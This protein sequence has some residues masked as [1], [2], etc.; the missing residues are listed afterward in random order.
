MRNVGTI[1]AAAGKRL[2]GPLKGIDVPTLL[3][4]FATAP[5]LHDG[6]A[7]TLADAVRAHRGV[8]INDADLGNL[9]AY[10]QQIGG[11]ESAAPVNA[12]VGTGLTGRYYNTNNLS[13]NV[14]L[15]RTEGVNFGWGTGSPG[16]GV[17]ADNFSVR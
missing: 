16:T 13:G 14:V 3:G 4:T 17:N 12:G 11:E 1:N 2:A 6:S 5:Y 7:P 10:L 9:V 8:S 15:T